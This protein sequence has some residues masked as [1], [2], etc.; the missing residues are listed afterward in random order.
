MP[1]VVLSEELLN[2]ALEVSINTTLMEHVVEDESSFPSPG[3]LTA[4][5]I[6]IFI[7]FFFLYV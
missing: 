2:L 7:I 6:P 4:V 5:P 3:I 1:D